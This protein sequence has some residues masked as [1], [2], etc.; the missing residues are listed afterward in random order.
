MWVWGF[1]GGFPSEALSGKSL[2]QDQLGLSWCH[3]WTQ[4]LAKDGGGGWRVF[5]F[6]IILT[7]PFQ[8]I[9]VQKVNSLLKEWLDKGI[10]FLHS[11]LQSL[12]TLSAV[13]FTIVVRNRWRV[14]SGQQTDHAQPSTVCRWHLDFLPKQSRLSAELVGLCDHFF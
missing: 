1:E 13:L 3:S 4:G 2:Q 9:D 7:S 12:G 5:Y 11:F 10:R 14:P 6:I 8:I